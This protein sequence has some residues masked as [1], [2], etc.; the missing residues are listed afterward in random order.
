VPSRPLVLTAADGNRFNAFEA[1]AAAPSAVGVIVLPDVRG[2]FPFYT[3]LALRFAEAGFDALAIDYFGR[4][5]GL[6]SRR[7]DF[8]Y[9]AHVPLQTYASVRADVEAAVV[10]LRADN[11]GRRIVTV[12][13]CIGGSNSWIQATNGFGLA[14]AVGFYGHPGRDFPTGGG[15]VIERL[16]RAEC[17]ILALMAG[18]DPGIPDDLVSQFRAAL[19]SHG[20]NHEIVTYPGAPHSFFDRRH[21]EFSSQSAD[22]WQRVL[23]FLSRA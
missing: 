20:V 7:D 15:S 19:E 6:E 8:D 12:G 11:V 14:G 10:H 13:F 17:P 2:L 22:A 23:E 21:E 4:T 9:K 5:A 16:D 1:L 18:D 3:E